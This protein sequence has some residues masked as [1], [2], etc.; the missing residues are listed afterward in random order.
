MGL[1]HPVGLSPVGEFWLGLEKVH[2]IAGGRGSRLA[3]Q[4]RDWEGNAE[5]LQ[6]PV[7]LGGEDT[8][9]SLQ[10]AAPVASELGATTVAPSGLSLPFS[11]WDQDH[12]LRRDKNCAKS[13][14]GEP[15]L[16]LP[17]L[18]APQ[19]QDH[20]SLPLCFPVL[21]SMPNSVHSLPTSPHLLSV[22][23]QLTYP[24]SSSVSP[25]LKLGTATVPTP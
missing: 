18:P 10:L 16:S 1:S 5:S 12:D 4:L 9:Y 24:L 15:A 13:L 11:T 20:A 14:S 8:A 23:G 6:F 2:R 22:S 21:P 25:S 3:V 17:V 19:G 7:H